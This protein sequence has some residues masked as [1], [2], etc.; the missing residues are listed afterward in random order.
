MYSGVQCARTEKL[1]RQAL[2]GWPCKIW[3][4]IF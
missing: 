3:Q 2:A 1:A 4:Y